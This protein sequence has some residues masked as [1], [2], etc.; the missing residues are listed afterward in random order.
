IPQLLP[1]GAR[2]SGSIQFNGKELLTVSDRGMQRYRGAEIACVYQEPMTALNP[3]HTVGDFLKEAIRSHAAF[4]A[5]G[6]QRD[7]QE[8]LDLVGLGSFD[9]LL[10]RYPHQLSG[11]QLQR[12]MAAGAIA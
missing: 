4:G 5:P 12:I 1:S 10:R 2:S 9:D 3:L 6:A 7:P 8:L 11:G